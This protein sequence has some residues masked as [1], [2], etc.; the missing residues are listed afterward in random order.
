MHKLAG[1]NS[2][3]HPLFSIHR[4]EN[5][6]LR[7][8]DFPKRMTYDFYTTGLKKNLSGFVKYGRTKYDFQEGALGFTAPYQLMEF[9][10]DLINNASGWIL[11]FH[12]DF[13]NSSGLQKKLNDYGFFEYHTNEGLH[14]SEEEEKSIEIIFENIE[15]EYNNPI[16]TYSKQVALSNLELLFTY[17]HR[18]YRRQFVIRNEVDSSVLTNFNKE[19]QLIFEKKSDPGL[20]TVEYLAERLNLSA[21]YLSDLLKSTTGKSAI[22]HIHGYLIELAKQQLLTTNYSIAEIAF[23]LGF[24]YPQYFSRLFKKKTGITPTQFRA[25]PE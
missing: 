17:S 25:T 15:K 9:S 21:N 10:S 4:I 3:K 20:P 2:P 13:L 16:D 5:L 19:L 18:Y 22:E 11:F 8:S 24:E 12:K 14:L 7:Y 1:L 6:E 23:E